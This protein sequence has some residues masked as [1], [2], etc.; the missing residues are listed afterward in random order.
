MADLGISG[1]ITFAAQAKTNTFCYL[2]DLKASL[3]IDNTDATS[4]IHRAT[5]SVGVR[6]GIFAFNLDTSMKIDAQTIAAQATVKQAITAYQAVVLGA[7]VEALDALKPLI[8][9]STGPFTIE[10]LQTIG[11]VQ[12]GLDTLLADPAAK[13]TPVLTSVTIDTTKVLQALT[14]N[15]VPPVDMTTLLKSRTFALERAYRAKTA[16]QAVDEVKAGKGPG[17]N[18]TLVAQTYETVLGLSGTQPVTPPLQQLAVNVL[19]AG[20]NL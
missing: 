4:V 13:L 7:G 16:Q 19:H 14:N 1:A 15:L 11:A 17:T 6:I 5:F 3:T 18:A 2:S 12:A 10:T 8:T 20:R 9:D